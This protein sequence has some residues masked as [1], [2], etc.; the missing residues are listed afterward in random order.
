MKSESGK[1][2]FV[3]PSFSG[4]DDVQTSSDLKMRLRRPMVVGAIVVGVFVFGLGLWAAVTP[5]SSGISAV[6]QVRVES[7][8]KTL[9]RREAG[10]VRAIYVKEGDRVRAGQPLI[11]FDETQ[12]RTQVTV[13]QNAADSFTAQSARFEA[14]ATGKGSISFP[15]ELMA[16]MSDP[17]VAAAVRDQQFLFTSRLQLHNSQVSVLNQRIDQ[18]D[19]RVEGL[20]AQV[21][22]IDEQIRL[23]EEEL[24]GYREL[25]AKGY[26]PKTLI[27]RYERSLAELSGR[28]GAT[29]S[30]I[31]RTREQMGE[32]RMQ[33]NSMRGERQS[34]AA[35]GLRDMQTRLADVTPRLA[36][37]TQTLSE[38]VIRAPVDGYVL[39]LTQFTI[40]GVAGGGEVLMDVVPANESLV[41]SAKVRPQDIDDIRIGMSAKVQLVGLN[42]RFVSP[43]P[44]TVMAVSA[45]Q[46]VDERNGQ[47]YFVADLRI[48]PADVAKS[49]NGARLKPGMPAQVLIVTGKRTIFSYLISP[50]TDTLHDAFREG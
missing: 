13:L 17:Q 50:I 10:T 12:A 27:L 20:Q 7:N 37:A 25:N 6:G 9:R 1:H 46:R 39:N 14:E 48:K 4:A 34:Q 5:I 29:I 15:K 22:S 21:D 35:E 33:L 8:R 3:V 28:K 2:L 31:T 49:I 30:D 24:S 36:A 40:G 47:G 43:I 18:L 16:R 11:L 44:A 19:T 41:V 26:A 42:Q 38:T 32:T 45:D 23:T